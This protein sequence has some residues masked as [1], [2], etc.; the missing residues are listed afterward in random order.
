[1]VCPSA[2][3]RLLVVCPEAPRPPFARF[4]RVLLINL[5]FRNTVRSRVIEQRISATC[6]HEVKRLP[7]K[8]LGGEQ[9]T[10]RVRDAS[11][12]L[13][14]PRHSRI[15]IGAQSLGN[16]TPSERRRWLHLS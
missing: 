2:P 9:R 11:V 8:T 10:R 15:G 3:R 7:G 14:L 5:P 12:G 4:P 13:D 16:R 6:T 1:M